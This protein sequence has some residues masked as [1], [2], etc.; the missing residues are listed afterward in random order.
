MGLIRNLVMSVTHLVFVGMDILAVMILVK[1]IYDRWHFAW[2]KPFA[3][4]FAPPVNSITKPLGTWLSKMTG[5]HYPEKTRLLLLVLCLWSIQV[6]AV[7]L[8]K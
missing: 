7:G 2:L 6:I 4:S 1:I 8:L 5:K 3:N